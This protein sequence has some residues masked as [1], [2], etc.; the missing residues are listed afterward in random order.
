MAPPTPSCKHTAF[1]RL[2]AAV[3]TMVFMRRTSALS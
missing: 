2:N 3:A 1:T